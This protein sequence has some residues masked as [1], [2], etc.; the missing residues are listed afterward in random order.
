MIG[1]GMLIRNLHDKLTKQTT[2]DTSIRQPI[3]A[4]TSD[5]L[6]SL[7]VNLFDSYGRREAGHRP[8]TA[9]NRRCQ[10]TP[11]VTRLKRPNA[12]QH[13]H[14]PDYYSLQSQMRAITS[15]HK[16]TPT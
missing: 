1:D 6:L 5:Q 14:S 3:S 9:F 4:Y 2:V 11:A 8:A 12:S 13:Q 16:L 7:L 15:R 10:Q